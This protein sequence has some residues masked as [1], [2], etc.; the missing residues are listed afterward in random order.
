[1]HSGWGCPLDGGDLVS[2]LSSSYFFLVRAKIPFENTY[3]CIGPCA[4]LFFTAGTASTSSLHSVP[5]GLW[6]SQFSLHR[7]HS[8]TTSQF[9]TGSSW[10]PPGGHL[11][12]PGLSIGY[13][14][15]TTITFPVKIVL[16]LCEYLFFDFNCIKITVALVTAVLETHSPIPPA[17]L[18][19]FLDLQHLLIKLYYAIRWSPWDTGWPN[20]QIHPLN[21]PCMNTANPYKD[22][23]F[24][25]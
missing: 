1:M 16:W 24:T 22:M 14:T 23:I 6:S 7:V 12:I 4:T 5:L 8:L 25:W 15:E 21:F 11:Q 9:E 13:V 2:S 19:Q 18:W 3:K 10:T 17:S 20:Q